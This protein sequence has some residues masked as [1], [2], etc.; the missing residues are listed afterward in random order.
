MIHEEHRTLYR[1]RIL[2]LEEN[3]SRLLN[4]DITKKQGL[5]QLPV[6]RS[7]IAENDNI[8]AASK[9]S[10]ESFDLM[11]LEDELKSITEKRKKFL[12]LLT[13]Q[14]HDDNLKSFGSERSQ[15][16]FYMKKLEVLRL[17]TE[18][19]SLQLQIDSQ[20]LQD[21]QQIHELN[22]LI[23]A[24]EP[25]P[26]DGGDAADHL[27][28]RKS[29]LEAVA[30]KDSE[31]LLLFL[32]TSLQQ[33][34]QQRVAGGELQFAVSGAGQQMQALQLSLLRDLQLTASGFLERLRTSLQA[35]KD[36]NHKVM[37]QYLVL[38]HNS[39]VAC[40]LLQHS[41]DSAAEERRSLAASLSQAQQAA[42]SERRQCEQVTAAEYGTRTE[43]LRSQV[44]ACEQRLAL[45]TARHTV[46]TARNRQQ[47]K[48]LKKQIRQVDGL[49]DSLQRRRAADSQRIQ[50]ELSTLRA[51]VRQA[52]EAVLS[53]SSEEMGGMSW[54]LYYEDSRPRPISQSLR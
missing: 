43:E 21:E 19:F 29:Q 48:S 44:V 2:R 38:R 45:L 15:D 5:S 50:Q 47:L 33:R 6:L 9:R 4:V 13:D 53:S 34:A 30:R 7:E 42:D 32:Q 36:L 52:E 14:I 51:Q 18:L 49:H 8:A 22:Y 3:L 27:Q 23:A 54:D 26:D 12:N 37:G 24:T 40:A 16:D 10:S 39:R 25:F 17:Q 1:N 46:T 31:S 20:R 41:K 11:F 28:S 35:A